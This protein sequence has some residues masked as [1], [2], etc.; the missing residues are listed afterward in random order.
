[1]LLACAEPFDVQRD[2]LGP[3][4]ITAI[5]VEDGVARAA[6]WSGEGMVHASSP[7]LAWTLDGEEL[8]EGYEVAV[9]GGGELGLVVTAADGSLH[10][11]RVTVAEP[12]GTLDFSREAVT[13]ID[14]D[15]DA[16]RALQG[17]PVETAVGEGEALRVVVDAAWGSARWMSDS[18][19]VLPLEEG[20]ADVLSEEALSHVL[21][22]VVD[23]E[24]GNRWEWIDAAY[25]G[26]PWIRHRGR[27]L[28][29]DLPAGLVA[30]TITGEDLVELEGVSDLASQDDLD[31]A[32]DGLPFELAW[33]T[34]GRCGLD[35]VDGARIV[36]ETW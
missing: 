25:G 5:G 6:I 1:M 10:Q 15:I 2:V 30:A 33:L 21:V 4:R 9:D 24:G 3:F 13:I 32:P 36:L 16:R 18:A 29:G 11:A 20:V 17:T 23:G 12:P 19:R 27:L 22:L 14:E 7:R 35:E 26:G 31:C 28:P 34:E 8:G